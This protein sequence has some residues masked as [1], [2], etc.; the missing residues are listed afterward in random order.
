M[1]M[2]DLSLISDNSFAATAGSP[3]VNVIHHG[4]WVFDH[5]SSDK[6]ILWYKRSTFD[7]VMYSNT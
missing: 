4:Y 5:K 1:K 6:E 3:N 2:N 7:E